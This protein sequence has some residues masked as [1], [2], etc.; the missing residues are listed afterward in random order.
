ML[1]THAIAED[2]STNPDLSVAQ[3]TIQVPTESDNGLS[4]NTK[5][6]NE[7]SGPLSSEN[8]TEKLITVIKK[9]K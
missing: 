3:Q 6:E 2:L 9:V 1:M 8:T 5:W 4:E 7:S